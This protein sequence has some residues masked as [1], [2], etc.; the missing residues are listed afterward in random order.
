MKYNII[1][2][3]LKKALYVFIILLFTTCNNQNKGREI[4]HCYSP[5]NSG[6]MQIDSALL[7]INMRKDTSHAGMVWI[8]NG[9]F[10][11]GAGEGEGF[12]EEYPQHNVSVDG[13]WMNTH[14]VTNAEFE[15]F[16]KATNY[17]TTAER[18]P[19]WEIMKLQLLAD[20]AK[21][22]DSLLVAGSL[23]FTPTAKAVALNDASQWWRFVP[24]ANWQHPDGPQSTIAGKEN[25]PVVQVSWEDAMAY[26]KWSGKRLPTEAEW[27]WAAKGG[28]TNAKYSWGNKELEDDFL[29]ANI[30]Q[31]NF[32]YKNLLQ[33]KFYTTAQVQSFAANGYG[34]YDMSGN[35]W[36][37][38]ADWM[39]A[40]YYQT[41]ADNKT[42]NPIG[43]ADG[44]ATTHPYQ[45]VLKGGS[46]LCHISYCSGYRTARRS[47]TGWDSGSN[48]AGF[49]CVK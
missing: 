29:P 3:A 27:E 36:E 5:G 43:P 26:C 33:D 35:V 41:A 21:P 30:W 15:A 49:R 13:F 46:F 28:I 18:K 44:G 9:E 7:K 2:I 16:V 6:I 23:V 22:E 1:A 14:E 10:I 12:A 17:I 25:H 4:L 48:H 31:G 34:L 39:D 20:A 19:D 32:P 38:C 40:N 24:G 11:M 42:N 45:K 47:S 37:W 8:S